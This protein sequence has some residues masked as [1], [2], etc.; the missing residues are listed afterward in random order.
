[1]KKPSNKI[2]Q[3]ILN[4]FIFDWMNGFFQK[5]AFEGDG[6]NKCLE[7][8]YLPVPISYHSPIPDIADLK[9]RRVWDKKSGLYGIDFNQK[10]QLV[11]L[12]KLGK[13]YGQECQ[14]PLNETKN[15]TQFYVNNCSFSFG[16]A[17]A[18]HSIIREFKPKRIIEIGSGNSSLII[19]GA[20]KLNKEAC[21]YD[22]IDPYPEEIIQRKK[23]KYH[24]LLPKKVESVNPN[25][26][27]N[28]KENDILFIDSSH[29]VK[30]GGDVNFLYLE[31]LPRL[32]PG[33]IVHIHDIHLPYE[34]H[35]VYAASETFRQFW[36]EQYLLQA[37]LIYNQEFEILLTM[38]FLMKD[39][40][41]EFRQAF[42]GYD[43][44]KHKFISSSFWLKRK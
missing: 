36:T 13:K 11:L 2:H 28:L 27:E 4:S 24:K 42:P 17:A 19:A 12:K 21:Q 7:K 23:I 37:F 8:G 10:N 15:K 44:K 34:Y 6:S 29:S 33:V 41:R 30:I 32:K 43:P 1:M 40:L 14:W 3:Y 20:L 31:I 25:S 9:K 5:I 35:Q 16:C 18:L 38:N 22:I 39:H 26:F